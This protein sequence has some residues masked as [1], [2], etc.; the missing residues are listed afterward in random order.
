MSQRRS[1][2]ISRS[3]SQNDTESVLD[4]TT[5]NDA[6]FCEGFGRMA[7]WRATSTRCAPLSP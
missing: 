1:P 6:T 3:L 7:W 2:A 5:A 4:S